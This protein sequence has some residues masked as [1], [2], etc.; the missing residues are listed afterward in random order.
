MQIHRVDYFK[1]YSPIAKLASF[2]LI[3]AITAHHSWEV[4]VFDFNGAYLN[5]K[6]EGDEETYMQQ[7]PGYKTGSAEWVMK[8]LKA[9][10]GLK[11]AGRRWYNVLLCALKELGFTVSA[12]NPGM[13]YAQ[14]GKE[15]LILVMHVNDCAMTG[16][17]AKLILEYK[18]KLNSCYPLTD[19]GPVYWL[20]SIKVTCDISVGTISLSQSTYINSIITCF[21]LTD[22]KLHNLPMIP[23]MSYS[24]DNSPSL[25]QDAA[26][27]HKVP[28]HKAVGSLMYA[29]IATHPDITFAV[30]TLSQFL[31]NTG[32]AYR[33]AM[34]CIFQYLSGIQHY[35]LTY[36]GERHNLVGYMDADGALQDHHWAISGHAF[37]IDGGTIS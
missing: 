16:S 20:L 30:S 26:C 22:A 23:S 8:L 33:E 17:C 4:H 27:M 3:L 15:L 7:P 6:L 37:L 10:Y 18:A 9:L 24:K 21:A 19:L 36:G 12:A 13:F 29:S 14:L 11:Q 31:E 35:A 32:E 25:Q 2:C 28:Y 34:K 5:G 1:N